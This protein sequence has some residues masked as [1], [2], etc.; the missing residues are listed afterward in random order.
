MSLV[1][2]SDWDDFKALMREAHDDF[3]T[4]PI[5]WKRVVSISSEFMEDNTYAP[6]EIQLQGQTN[7][8]YL[9]S[10]PITMQTTSGELDRQT[11]Q[12]LFNKDY[13]RELGYINTNNYFEFSP[14][15]DRFIIDGITYKELGDTSASLANGDDILVT[16]IL[17]RE[18]TNTGSKK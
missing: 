18:E 13:L 6:E 16:L 2:Q 5:L 7:Y 3:E 1:N 9:R 12:V 8:N 4:K 15:L 11:I 10:W 14:D 17:K